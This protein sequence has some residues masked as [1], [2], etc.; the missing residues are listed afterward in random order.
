MLLELIFNAL[1]NNIPDA[2][3]DNIPSSRAPVGAKNP[4]IID[5]ASTSFNLG[6]ALTPTSKTNSLKAT[7][8]LSKHVFPF[9]I[10]LL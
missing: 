1:L 7:L 6:R 10:S 8:V 2:R 5:I 4:T 3:T 9:T